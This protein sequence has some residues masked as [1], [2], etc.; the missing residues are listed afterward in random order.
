MRKVWASLITTLATLVLAKFVVQPQLG[1][2]FS[3]AGAVGAE[4]IPMSYWYVY[5]VF[6]AAFAPQVIYY[7]WKSSRLLDPSSTVVALI[8]LA[9]ALWV[10]RFLGNLDLP[11]G[12]NLVL[13]GA[14]LSSTFRF[15][16]AAIYAAVPLGILYTSDLVIPGAPA[17]RLPLPSEFAS[18]LTSLLLFVCALMAIRARRR[19]PSGHD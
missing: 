14:L 3:G 7:T 5:F 13:F 6:Y 10:I 18:G 19:P 15:E 8:L 1:S 4:L 12:I 2:I 9:L 11:T 16:R 17:L